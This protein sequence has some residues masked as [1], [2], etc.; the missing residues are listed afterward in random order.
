MM[1]W[2]R[3]IVD[4]IF[5]RTPSLVQL[6]LQAP[7]THGSSRNR[8][9]GPDLPKRP[10]DPDSPVRSPRRYGP[11]G[12]C[13]SVAIAEPVDDESLVAVGGPLN[14]AEMKKVILVT[15]VA[16]ALGAPSAD[17]ARYRNTGPRQAEAPRSEVALPS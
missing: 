11:T 8:W 2:L 17:Q 1:G 12:R 10:H 15:V 3:T 9:G 14:G 16:L 5:G 13:A 4:W 6:S 7:N